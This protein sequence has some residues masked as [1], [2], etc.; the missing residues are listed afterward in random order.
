[1]I[2]R[3]KWVELDPTERKK[4]LASGNYTYIPPNTLGLVEGFYLNDDIVL[5]LRRRRADP[6][7]VKFIL[8]MLEWQRCLD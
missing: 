6:Q 5:M 4:N 3:Q 2:T 8:D 1:M 7:V